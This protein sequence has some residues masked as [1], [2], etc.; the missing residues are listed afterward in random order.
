MSNETTG[1]KPIC[2]DSRDGCL[3]R[4]LVYRFI[5]ANTNTNT[6][7]KMKTRLCSSYGEPWA[8]ARQAEVTLHCYLM[9]SREERFHLGFFADGETHVVRQCRE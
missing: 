1:W 7:V 6:K 9:E 2:H 3:P 8:T 4:P 5:P